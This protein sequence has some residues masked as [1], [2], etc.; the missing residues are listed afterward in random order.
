[1]YSDRETPSCVNMER[2]E[3]FGGRAS[4]SS[5][6]TSDCYQHPN[7]SSSNLDS[8]EENNNNSDETSTEGRMSVS[9]FEKHIF[10]DF[11]HFIRSNA[12]S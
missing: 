6:E 9:Y 7:N 8:V 2:N 1:M 11:N 3:D 5:E 4:C 10:P 12:I